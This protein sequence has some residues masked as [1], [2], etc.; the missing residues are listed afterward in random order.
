MFYLNKIDIQNFGLH[1]QFTHEF[2]GHLTGIIGLNGSGK[3]TLRQAIEW[4]LRGTI[5]HKDPITDFVHTADGVKHHPM[6]VTLHFTAD[7]RKGSITRRVTAS[8]ATRSL[9]L[10]GMEGGKP[11]TSEKQVAEV[12]EQILGVDKQALGGSVFLEQGS[13]RQMFGDAADRRNLYMRILG[14]TEVT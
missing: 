11:V 8:A 13:L 1:K 2:N 6:Q 4:G 3:S 10:E 12:M 9:T 7:G 14:L 5:T